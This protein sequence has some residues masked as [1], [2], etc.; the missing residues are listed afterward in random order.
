MTNQIQ[1]VTETKKRR[2]PLKNQKTGREIFEEIEALENAVEQFEVALSE[3]D[4]SSVAYLIVKVE[5]D[6]AGAALEA[7]LTKVHHS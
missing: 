7:A 3:I 4:P 6:K 2:A 5:A 1:E